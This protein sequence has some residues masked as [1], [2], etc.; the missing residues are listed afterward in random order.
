MQSQFAPKS[1]TLAFLNCPDISP[2]D[3]RIRAISKR[4]QQ[5]LQEHRK[6]GTMGNLEIEAKIGSIVNT[7]QGN[8][9]EQFLCSYLATLPFW[10]IMHD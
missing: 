4:L 9:N 8:A 5:T 3:D 7:L 6:N 10:N 1:S 2:S